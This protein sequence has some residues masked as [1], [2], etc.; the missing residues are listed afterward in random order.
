MPDRYLAF[1]DLALSAGQWDALQ[2]PVSV[3]FFF[4]N[5]TLDRVCR[6]L[7]EPGRRH[8]VAAAARHLGRAGRGQPVLGALEPDVEALLVRADPRGGRPECFLVPIDACYELVGQ[9]RRLWRGFDGGQEATRARA[10]FDEVAGRAQVA[11]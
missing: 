10:F 5:S 6:L 11:M 3:A 4:L 7:P 1:P 9:L 2:I 8:R